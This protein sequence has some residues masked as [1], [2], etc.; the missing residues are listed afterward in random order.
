VIST[1]S[2]LGTEEPQPPSQIGLH[3]VSGPDASGLAIVQATVTSGVGGE[4]ELT[5]TAPNGLAFESGAQTLQLSLEPNTATPAGQA[6]VTVPEGESVTVSARLTFKNAD[7]ETTMIID[8][9][10]ILGDAQTEAGELLVP[11]VMTDAE[12][13]RTVQR[14]PRAEAERM[15]ERGLGEIGAE[16][17]AAPA[18]AEPTPTDDGG[19]PLPRREVQE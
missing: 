8:E 2:P 3:L 1:T 15:A 10:I 9:S 7:G 16:G 18:P 4:A 5:L 12:G 13:N 6:V 14:L 19:D 11:F 17:A